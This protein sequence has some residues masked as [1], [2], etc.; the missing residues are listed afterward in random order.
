MIGL[1]LYTI[2][3]IQ[4][5]KF[6]LKTTDGPKRLLRYRDVSSVSIR[7]SYVRRRE[8]S[9]DLPRHDSLKPTPFNAHELFLTVDSDV[10]NFIEFET[11]RL[12]SL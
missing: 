11:M 2:F 1:W 6:D 5:L 7:V 12:T 3:L 4:Q 9:Y 8:A 10:I